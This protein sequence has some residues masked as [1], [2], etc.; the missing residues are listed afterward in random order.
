MVGQTIVVTIV[1]IDGDILTIEYASPV[2]GEIIAVAIPAQPNP[3]PATDTPSGD[4]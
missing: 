3:Q 1:A 2:T 4:Y